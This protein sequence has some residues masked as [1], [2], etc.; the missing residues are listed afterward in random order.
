MINK[1]K[2]KEL[3]IDIEVLEQKKAELSALKSQFEA[4][5]KLLIEYIKNLSNCVET[6]KNDLSE[7]AKKEFE[8]TNK[9][10]LTGGLGIRESKEI[11][12]DE[13]KA[14]EW[15]KEKDLFL[16]L[17]KKGFEKAASSMKLDFVTETK[18]IGVTF[19]KE[20]LL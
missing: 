20:I 12:Y 15:A 8:E 4:D 5:N 13:T 14:L 7:E 17:D 16:I 10:S 18:K 11:T 1:E 2:L 6:S 3:K 19:P 9:K